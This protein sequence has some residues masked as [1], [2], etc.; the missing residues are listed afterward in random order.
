MEQWDAKTWLKRFESEG[1]DKRALRREVWE[2]TLHI[3]EKGG[4]NRADRAFVRIGRGYEMAK[5]SR[6]YHE[7]TDPSLKRPG[8]ETQITVTASD[9]LDVAR[10]WVRAGMEAGK[11]W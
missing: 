9:C 10:E 8:F 7:P 1:A 6:L 5:H 11:C 4:Y 3:V 2:N